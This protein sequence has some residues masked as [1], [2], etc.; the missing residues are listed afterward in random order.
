[1]PI[2]GVRSLPPPPEM[3]VANASMDCGA[4]RICMC[5]TEVDSQNQAAVSP[6]R[7]RIQGCNELCAIF[8][9]SGGSP[10]ERFPIPC[11]RELEIGSKL[12]EGPQLVCFALC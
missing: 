10:S 8:A 9:A 3:I 11:R 5:S 12:S 6:R 2:G 7:G 4:K 1:M